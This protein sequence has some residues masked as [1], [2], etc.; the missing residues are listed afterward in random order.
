METITRRRNMN[1]ND[2]K[3]HH[4]IVMHH[5]R[6]YNRL[7]ELYEEYP[8]L[9]YKNKGWE[10]LPKEAYDNHQEQ[11]AEMTQICKDTILGFSKLNHFVTRKNGDIQLRVQYVW[12]TSPTHFT[13]VGYFDIDLLKEETH[14][15]IMT[16]K[17]Q[18]LGYDGADLHRLMQYFKMETIV[19][20]TLDSVE[21]Q[22][23]MVRRKNHRDHID[24]LIDA[25][26][27]N[28]LD[29]YIDKARLGETY[30]D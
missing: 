11:L 7:K 26:N 18:E 4:D 6:H 25:K 23:E 12:S 29:E 30:Y 14:N 10:S 16:T 24:R 19:L 22:N 28:K 15:A 8:A 21:Y 9:T 20:D 17:L 5:D 1:K 27:K 3:Y 13:G 2:T